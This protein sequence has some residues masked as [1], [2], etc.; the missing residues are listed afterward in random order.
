MAPNLRILIHLKEKKEITGKK[1][2]SRSKVK[3]NQERK[4]T[5]PK[6][7]RVEWPEL[8]EEKTKWP[9]I[10]E[11]RNLKKKNRIKWR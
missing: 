3:R 2:P 1:A 5:V 10:G 11:R 8:G 6:E 4:S 7:G 9:K